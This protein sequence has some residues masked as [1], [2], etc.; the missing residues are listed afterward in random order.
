MRELAIVHSR[1]QIK[2]L[3]MRRAF[4]IKSGVPKSDMVSSNCVPPLRV[5]ANEAGFPKHFFV[6]Q[7][8]APV[9]PNLVELAPNSERLNAC[10]NNSERR[11]G[12][13]AANTTTVE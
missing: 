3:G 9:R 11:A 12:P 8:S 5:A 1:R 4:A 6:R 13:D 10:L 2:S 7:Q